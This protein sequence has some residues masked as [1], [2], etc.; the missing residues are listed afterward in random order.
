M[1]EDL[2][3]QVMNV[4]KR[5]QAEGL[6]KHKSGNFSQR[7][8][9]TGLVVITPT[10][11]DREML[12]ADDMVVCDA[13]AR[14][15]ES[16]HALRPT[17]ELL[18][19]LKAYE[20][21]PDVVAIVHT[22]SMYATTFAVLGRP[23]PAVVYEHSYLGCA[24]GVVPVAPYGR[25]GTQALADSVAGPAIE[26][27]TFLLRSHGAVAL[28]ETDIDGA[29]LKACYLEEVAELYYLALTAAGGVEPEALP[30][31]E[32]EKWAYPEQIKLS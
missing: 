15:V 29:Y 11:V 5:A 22:H 10:G 17:S 32:L 27:D 24:H 31:E 16:V 9:E 8:P 20:V 23:I 25:P 28:D 26:N 6:C 19:H 1:L 21:R 2:K 13:G 7:D 3:L 14:V 4:A 30:A 12:T 18:M